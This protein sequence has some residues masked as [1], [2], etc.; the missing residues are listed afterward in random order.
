MTL[1]VHLRFAP[2]RP[3]QQAA[4]WFLPGAD[5]TRW[6]AELTRCGLARL[7]T[8]VFRVPRSH[9]DRSTAGALII[10]GAGISPACKPA[11]L[12]CRLVAG[13]LFLPNDA[14]LYPPV[15]DQE[16][17]ELCPWPVAFFHPIFGLSGFDES[18]SA[19]MSQWLEKTSLRAINWNL[20]RA[21]AAPLPALGTIVL[22]EVPELSQLFGDA[23]GEIGTD[24]PDDLPPAPDEQKNHPL[25]Q[26][27]GKLK[28][29]F[30][31]SLQRLLQSVPHTATRRTW[32]NDAE[33]WTRNKLQALNAG[34]DKIRNKELH[35][36][37]HMLD[38]DPEAG[39]RHAIPL[40]DFAHRGLSQPG[41]KL[42]ERLPDFNLSRIGGG[43]PA[44]FWHVPD[45]LQQVLR[46]RYREMAD[47]ELQL[48]RFHRA[49][50]IYAELLGD[51]VSAAHTLKQGKCYRDAAILYEEHLHN[52]LEA[53]RCFAEAG[54][55]AE[56]I[57]RYEKLGRWLEMAELQKRMG[58]H[59]GAARSI[60]RMVDEHLGRDDVLSAATLV[61][62]QL[63]LPEEA[64]DLLENAWPSS[65]QAGSCLAPLFQILARLG[66][67]DRALK[68]LHRFKREP[69][70]PSHLH[71]LLNALNGVAR[72]F[73]SDAGRR[74]AQDLSRVLIAGQ[75]QRASADIGEIAKCIDHLT[76]LAPEDRLLSRDA[77]THL[78]Q[79]RA[80][81][82]TTTMTLPAPSSGGRPRLHRTFDL[83]RQIKWI[84]L[85]REWHWFFALG[86]TPKRV[87]LLRGGW[88]GEFQ[89]LSWNCQE[90]LIPDWGLF[91]PTGE[92]GS[93]VALAQPGG[94]LL[95]L[96]TFPATD[97]FFA[98]A[99]TAGTL[100]W[101]PRQAYPVAFG[102]DSVWSI[103]LAA[104]RAVLSCHDKHGHLS[105]TIDITAELLENAT[106]T[107]KSRL[108][109]AAVSKHV[110]AALGN[111]LVVINP[112]GK[113]ER[114]E[115]PGQ[116][117]QLTSTL[118]HTRK[119][120][121]AL[122]EHGA[123]MHCFGTDQWIELDR[124]LPAPM[125]AFVPGGPLVLISGWHA[126]LLDVDARGVH[127]VT[128]M[129]LSGP[130]PVAVCP[131]AYTGEFAVL[132]ATGQVS[133]YQVP[134]GS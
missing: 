29:Q 125:A 4:A 88:D 78:D 103:H 22:R 56:A 81:A 17:R 73:P 97:S 71:A 16:L 117:L 1:T 47:R 10:P 33:D 67:Q 111:R 113:T 20:A 65:R 46:R 112:A 64:A 129:D 109:I 133:V 63:L 57:E 115:V 53:A 7:S 130:Q 127:K 2:D 43:G 26:A 94:P 58:D 105:R 124:D 116:I 60:R 8:R 48:G 108:R 79:R 35:R 77:H 66:K 28:Y 102:E 6:L 62:Q 76:R 12:A 5:V 89:S 122:L 52:P 82:L 36:L 11:G 114:L 24:Q 92:Q 59:L 128:R 23:P 99:C 19:D 13:K 39:L 93:S 104:G 95:K 68:R 72:F 61:D 32:I 18:A 98:R 126:V 131:T 41:S 96:Q 87:T 70:P 55:L 106:R 31:R 86:V 27:A 134:R 25:S 121:V 30:F 107:E 34:L 85:Q 101:L 132:T 123:F 80:R 49:A 74:T 90:T 3:D 100:D 120:I 51:L 91:E 84:R 21:G 44:D 38:K 118:L 54:L 50:Y 69:V 14:M 83:P 9:D 15:T 37:L 40:N 110:V 75:L 45:H 42:G 119:G